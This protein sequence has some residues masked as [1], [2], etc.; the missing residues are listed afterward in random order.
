MS[1]G[2]QAGCSRQTRLLFSSAMLNCSY[3]QQQCRSCVPVVCRR[4]PG[5]M[6]NISHYMWGWDCNA[7]YATSCLL[8][9][10]MPSSTSCLLTYVMI[11]S[12]TQLCCTRQLLIQW[13]FTDFGSE[14]LTV[15]SHTK[16]AQRRHKF[17]SDAYSK[18]CLAA[19]DEWVNNHRSKHLSCHCNTV[20]M[21]EIHAHGS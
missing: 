20:W 13:S 9:Y 18:R 14:M 7:T 10:V 16:R 12:L 21:G 15:Y 19:T 17:I 2:S 3:T 6:T 5:G 8:C 11:P 4:L 1:Y